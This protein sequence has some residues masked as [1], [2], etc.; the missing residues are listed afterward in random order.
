MTH[1]PLFFPPSSLRVLPFPFF[2]GLGYH[3]EKIVELKMFVYVIEHFG[4]LM[5]LIISLETKR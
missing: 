1:I 3:D 4:G 5:R 2:E